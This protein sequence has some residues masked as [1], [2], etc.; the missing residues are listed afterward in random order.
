MHCLC[1]DL[2]HLTLIM[3]LTSCITLGELLNLS[4]PQFPPL[5]SGGAYTKTLQKVIKRIM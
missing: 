4:V 5:R 2:F 3:L 1:L